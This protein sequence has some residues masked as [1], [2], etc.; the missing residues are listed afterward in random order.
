MSGHQ[1]SQA[2]AA[3]INYTEDAK[4]MYFR[5]LYNEEDFLCVYGQLYASVAAGITGAEF[6]TQPIV[7]SLKFMKGSVDGIGEEIDFHNTDDAEN[8]PSIDIIL[9]PG[10][11]VADDVNTTDESIAE[12]GGWEDVPEDWLCPDCGLGKDEFEMIEL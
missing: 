8:Y 7:P 4:D 3:A 11:A 1:R 9:C 5:P 12:I 10:V 6:I 2:L